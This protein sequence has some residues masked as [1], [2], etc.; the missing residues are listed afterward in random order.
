MK[1]IFLSDIFITYQVINISLINGDDYMA[2]SQ[3]TIKSQ[4]T[5][6][7]FTMIFILLSAIG[8]VSFTIKI[9]GD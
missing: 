3:F 1:N 7:I 2:N 9:Q 8:Y 6:D 4:L 5:L